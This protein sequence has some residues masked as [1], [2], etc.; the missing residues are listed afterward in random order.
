MK[1]EFIICELIAK[2]GEKKQGFINI[3]NTETKMPVTIINGANE[4]STVLITAGVHG[5]EYPC[6]KT[7][8]ELAKEID[9]KKVSGQIIIVHPVNTQG[10]V[11]RNAAVVPEDNKNILRVFPGDKNGTISEKIAYVISNDLQEKADFY[12]DIHGGDIH[13]DLLPHIYYPGL[14][15]KSIIEASINMAKSFNVPYYVKSNTTNG[16]YTSAAIRKNIPSLLI[17]RGGCGLCKEEDVKEYK[18]D[19]LN[20]LAGLN[21][22][23]CEIKENKFSPREIK[24]AVYLEALNDGCWT[25]FVKAGEEIKEGEKLGEVTDYFGNIIDT[26]YAKFDAVVL[27]NTVAYSVTKDSSLIAY[28]RI[29]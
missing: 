17:E 24:E 7:A 12:L 2:V 4:G 23:D 11:G 19:I 26:Y 13:E 15:D 10:F 9:P 16:T 27:Y 20:V 8:I 18:R 3:L 6:I 25:C 22:L 5:G 21:I 14:A 29:N 28:G 1:K